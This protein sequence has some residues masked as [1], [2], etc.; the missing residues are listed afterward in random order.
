MA[1]RYEKVTPI[2]AYIGAA[3]GALVLS[4]HGLVGTFVGAA[5]G[6][7]V[8]LVAGFAAFWLRHRPQ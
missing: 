1:I 8:G 5:I 7:I 3:I 2:P 4:A 6:I